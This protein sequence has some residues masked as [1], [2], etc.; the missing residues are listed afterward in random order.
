MAGFM[1]STAYFVPR[2]H[3]KLRHSIKFYE[4]LLRPD[5]AKWRSQV[6]QRDGDKSLCAKKFLNELIPYFIEVVM[7]DS[8]YFIRDFPNHEFSRLLVVSVVPVVCITVC[9]TVLTCSYCTVFCTT[10]PT[11]KLLCL[12][13]SKDVGFEAWA[14]TARAQVH[15]IERTRPVDTVRSLNAGC[16]EAIE[17][18][19]RRHDHGMSEMEGLK[20]SVAAL[21]TQVAGL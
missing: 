18:F 14:A 11:I 12:L 19:H 17:S 3:V 16:Q 5:L 8:I 6:K 21:T 4:E 9:A 15:E 20:A 10:F 2:T 1:K 7:Q 13:Q